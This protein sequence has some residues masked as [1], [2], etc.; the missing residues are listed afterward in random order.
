MLIDDNQY[1]VRRGQM[2]TVYQKIDQSEYR[3]TPQRSVVLQV[4]IE[5]QGHHLSAEDVLQ[6]ARKKSPNIGIATV[7]RTLEKL[8]SMDVLY[9]TMFEGGRYRYELSIGDEHQHHHII[10]LSC[11]SITEVEDDLLHILENK[12]EKKGFR[13][14]DHELKFYGYCPKCN[15]KA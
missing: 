8:A 3:L 13:V 14:V 7:Y 12:L 4:M 15:K 10:C 1:Q 11:G 6:E 9:K 2:K 5:N